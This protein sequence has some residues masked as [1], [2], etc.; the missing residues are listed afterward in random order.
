MNTRIVLKNVLGIKIRLNHGRNMKILVT[1]GAGFIGSHLSDALIAKGYQVIILDN[2]STGHQKNIPR[3]ATFVLGDVT[4]PELVSNL[5][6]NVDACFHLAAIPSV[7]KSHKDWLGCHHVNLKGSLVVFDA[8]SKIKNRKKIPIIYASS[9]AVYG[10][11]SSHGIKETDVTKPNSAYGVD[12]LSTELQAQIATDIYEIPTIGMRFFNVYGP[13]QNSH[14]LYSGVIT[15]FF[16]CLHAK[17]P[18]IIYGDGEQRRDFIYI[19]DIVAGLISALE[20]N[21]KLKSEIF[22]V[23]TGIGTSINLLAQ[24]M[25]NLFNSKLN[26]S[27]AEPKAGDIKN[28]IGDGSKAKEHLNF[29]TSFSLS[30]GLIQLHEAICNQVIPTK[31]KLSV[32][33]LDPQEAIY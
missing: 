26:I 20:S 25:S 27:Y 28:S 30:E 24:T 19:K 31:Q 6:F 11:N 21:I 1:G 33:V 5:V 17:A 12:K 15:A 7:E 16:E 23:C 13:R 10:N 3:Q 2:L 14:S 32:N 9:A 22:N 4:N 18:F 29:R 8:V